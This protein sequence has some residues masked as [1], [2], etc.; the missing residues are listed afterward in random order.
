MNNNAKSQVHEN[1]YLCIGPLNLNITKR[2]ASTIKGYNI[3]LEGKDFEVLCLLAE[4]EGKYLTFKELCE[5]DYSLSALESLIAQINEIGDKFM[6][7]KHEPEQGYMFETRWGKQWNQN[8]ENTEKATVQ[9]IVKSNIITITSLIRGAG[10][11]AAAITLVL[12]FLYSIGVFSPT[13]TE[14]IYIDSEIEIEGQKVP[15]AAA[16]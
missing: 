6:W 16:P 10:L 4:N 9:S 5:E 11:I 14:P 7:I 13:N 15:L 2:E 1:K 3:V 8:V 12:M